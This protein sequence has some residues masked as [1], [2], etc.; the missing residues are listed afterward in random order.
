LKIASFVPIPVSRDPKNTNSAVMIDI[1]DILL[2]VITSP[3]SLESEREFSRTIEKVEVILRCKQLNKNFTDLA[4]STCLGIINVKFQPFWEPVIK[5]I[6]SDPESIFKNDHFLGLL[7]EAVDSLFFIKQ[8]GNLNRVVDTP[9]PNNITFLYEKLE[10]L[11]NSDDGENTIDSNTS[12]SLIFYLNTKDFFD[13]EEHMN[14]SSDLRSDCETI[15]KNLWSIIKRC[16]SITLTKSKTIVPMFFKFLNEQYYLTLSED[17]EIID[18]K[19]IKVINTQI[20]CSSNK[21]QPQFS[22]SILKKRLEIFLQVFAA[23]TSPKQL[24]NYR[25]LYSLYSI[26]MS[27]PDTSIAKLAFDCIL[28][29]KADSV[30]PYK[31]NI[32]RLLNDSTVREELLTFTIAYGKESDIDASTRVEALSLIIYTIY[33][34]FMSKSKDDNKKS[35]DKS[36]AKKNAILQFLSSLSSEELRWF[37]YLMFRG[38][39]SKQMISSCLEK[40]FESNGIQDSVNG[41]SQGKNLLL[42]RSSMWF[43]VIEKEVLTIKAVNFKDIRWEK[44]LAYIQILENI[45]K[46]FGFKITPYIDYFLSFIFCILENTHNWRSENVL[47]KNIKNQSVE[48]FDDAPLDDDGDEFV[49]LPEEL[50]ETVETEII[51]KRNFIL[52]SKIRTNTFLRISGYYCFHFFKLNNYK[53]I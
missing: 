46:I 39:L 49:E 33:G 45:I 11:L 31:E 38:L 41:R 32:K 20:E 4:L 17:P 25:E 5:T 16:P 23:V 10:N 42:D 53:S 14:L 51:N 52:T 37:I 6:L 43:D 2:D 24:Y 9:T 21:A 44:Q 29:Y 8:T 27:K 40:Y 50:N 13:E 15:N 7:F 30:L 19:R 3:I 26:F 22:I 36:S 35:K 48:A 28:T 12:Q 47:N 18:L 34:R 1:V